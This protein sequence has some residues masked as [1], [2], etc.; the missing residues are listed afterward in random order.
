MGLLDK[1]AFLQWSFPSLLWFTMV[2]V[3]TSSA[4]K[5]HHSFEYTIL[6]L[7]LVCFLFTTANLIPTSFDLL[8]RI[9]P[10]STQ[11]TQ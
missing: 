10:V 8:D 6:F 2:L 1:S 4:T 9:C 3:F 7:V 5:N 11:S